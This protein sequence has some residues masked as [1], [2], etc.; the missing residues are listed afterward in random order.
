M[1]LPDFT[2]VFYPAVPMLQRDLATDPVLQRSPAKGRVLQ[3]SLAIEPGAAVQHVQ[4]RLLATRG[5]LAPSNRVD[6]HADQH[7]VTADSF[8]LGDRPER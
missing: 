3:Y 5:H 4:R 8:T 7:M 1:N 6:L 2:K